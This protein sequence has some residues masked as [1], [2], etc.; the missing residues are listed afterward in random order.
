MQHTLCHLCM[1]QIVIR[2]DELAE[3]DRALSLV[4]GLF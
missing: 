1:T 4:L 2:A 3:V